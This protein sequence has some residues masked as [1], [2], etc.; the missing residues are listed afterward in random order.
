MKKHKTVFDLLAAEF[1]RA[2]IPFILVGGFAVNHYRFSRA[3]AD[4]DVM[5]TE[6]NYERA[7]PLLRQNGYQETVRTELFARLKNN[8][9]L[10]IDLDILFVDSKT[11]DGIRKE[12]GE[13]E[14]A[15]RKISVPSLNH[16]IALKL[17]SLKNNAHREIPDL[18]DIVNLIKINQLNP[19]QDSF[20][21]L[22]LKYGT[23]E[24][25][26]KIRRATAE[27]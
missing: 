10:M 3:T 21:A 5:M 4:V 23:Q 1:G 25:Y 6:E 12:S 19:E 14:I 22:C 27:T 8:E 17:H 24:L 2:K 7:L 20:K 26:D 9:S 13:T 18:A 11:F 16:L 15:G